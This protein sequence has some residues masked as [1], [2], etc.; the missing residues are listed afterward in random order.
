MAVLAIKLR[1]I[2]LEKKDEA[3]GRSN[4]VKLEDVWL[5]P[6]DVVTW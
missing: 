1:V 6:N 5:A 2:A 4:S 3:G